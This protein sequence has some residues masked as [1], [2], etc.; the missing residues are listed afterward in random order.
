MAATSV[1]LEWRDVALVVDTAASSSLRKVPARLAASVRGV[2]PGI[3]ATV[4]PPPFADGVAAATTEVTATTS[5]AALWPTQRALLWGVSGG[6][7]PGQVMAILGPSGAGKTTLLNLLAGRLMPAAGTAVRGTVTVNGAPR[8]AATF[9][10]MTAYVEQDDALYAELTVR[11][12]LEFTA[13]LRLPQS[14]SPADRSARVEAVLSELGLSAVADRRVGGGAVRGVSG[15]E[16]K[17]T[18]I[19]MELVTDPQLLLCDE[20]TAGLD[21]AAALSVVRTLKTLAVRGRKTVLTTIHQPRGDIFDSF[22]VVM[23]LS[24]GHVMYCGPP[25]KAVAYFEALGFPC[26]LNTNVADFLLDIVTPAAVKASAFRPQSVAEGQSS[27]SGKA[28][29]AASRLWARL[30]VPTLGRLGLGSSVGDAPDLLQS[31]THSYVRLGMEAGMPSNKSDAASG[32]DPPTDHVA[33]FAAAYERHV[34]AESSQRDLISPSMIQGSRRVRFATPVISQNLAPALLTG[35]GVSGATSRQGA[36]AT[37]PWYQLWVLLHRAYL[38]EVRNARSLMATVAQTA[39]IGTMLGITFLQVGRSVAY[40]TGAA[41]GV[42]TVIRLLGIFGVLV[43]VLS[44]IDVHTTFPLERLI[45]L[46]ERAAHSYRT[47]VYFAAYSVRGILRGVLLS[48]LL[49]MLMA[50]LAGLR[51]SAFPAIV[52]VVVL[53]W[54]A[55]ESLALVVAA[56]L[57]DIK[58]AVSVTPSLFSALILYSGFLIK[59]DRLPAALRWIHRVSFIGYAFSGMVRAQLE[60]AKFDAP[61]ECITCVSSGER[62]LTSYGISSTAGGVWGSAAAL[63]ATVAVLRMVG[64]AVV[65]ARGPSFAKTL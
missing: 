20:P 22:D 51:W 61:L 63:A 55:Y 62:A 16:R 19:G 13:R 37:S 25:S 44:I 42:T 41:T 48:V 40:T 54:I 47:S 52:M 5:A 7:R 27:A 49:T 64:Y 23:L 29:C 45:M 24:G 3:S 56:S 43:G 30:G 21:A 39:A 46:R 38:L 15:G 65:L 6:V 33:Y 57:D 8:V 11:E 32:P 4:L 1:H 17:R 31:P 18:S 60:G 9:R 58:T 53:L 34:A 2:A 26:P 28:A 35:D 10:H 36:Y 14:T 12:Q 59:P 50:V